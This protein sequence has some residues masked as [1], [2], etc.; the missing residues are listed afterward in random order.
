M[1]YTRIFSM[2][3]VNI[4]LHIHITFRSEI[5]ICGSHRVSRA[6]IETRT[7]RDGG[8]PATASSVH[9]SD[10]RVIFHQKCAMLRCCG[11]VWLPSNIFIGTH[12]LALGRMRA[13]DAM[14]APSIHCILE[15]RTA[16]LLSLVL[17][18]MKKKNKQN[19]DKFRTNLCRGNKGIS[20]AHDLGFMTPSALKEIGMVAI[21][22]KDTADEKQYEEKW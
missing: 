16:Q 7:L 13:T 12:S 22:I 14:R 9:C 1:S 20:A 5:T 10:V 21:P 15:H 4:Q 3:Y 19:E 17:M 11:C 6:V 18:E 2:L 8:C